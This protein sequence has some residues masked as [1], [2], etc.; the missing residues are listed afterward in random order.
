MYED[1]VGPK[2]TGII[3]VLGFL[4][5]SLVTMIN[6]HGGTDQLSTVKNILVIQTYNRGSSI[7]DT[8]DDYISESI[9]ESD[10]E[11]TNIF[12]EYLDAFRLK[13]ASYDGR[14][15]Q[16]LDLKYKDIKFDGVLCI[17]KSA[18]DFVHSYYKDYSGIPMAYIE[19]E[20]KLSELVLL[21]E[22]VGRYDV[23]PFEAII[24][25][26]K[27]LNPNLKKIGIYAN[28][29]VDLAG[30]IE[31]LDKM[32]ETYNLLYQIYS[33]DK[34][35]QYLDNM[36]DVGAQEASLLLSSLYDESGNRYDLDYLFE[37]I[38]K[39]AK[40]PV[41][42]LYKSHVGKGSTGTVLYN[43]ALYIKQSV[44]SFVKKLEGS[45]TEEELVASELLTLTEIYDYNKIKAMNLK[46]NN[47]GK[48]AIIINRPSIIDIIKNNG[49]EVVIIIF[50]VLFII[51]IILIIN[52]LLRL[53]AEKDR[54][55]ARSD[56]HL[57]YI[58][59]EAAHGQLVASEGELARQYEEL[60]LK[61]DELRKSRERYRLA[62]KGAEFGIWDYDV[63]FQRI[64]FS[65]KAREVL[66]LPMN[67]SSF[68]KEEVLSKLNKEQEATFY[69][70][71]KEHIETKTKAIEY[72]AIIEIEEG[73]KEWISVRGKA[74]F[75]E[76][77]AIKR[78]AGSIT[79]ITREKEA[80]ERIRHI[81][82]TDELTSFHNRAYFNQCIEG[83]NTYFDDEQIAILFI[84][85]DNFKTVN[86]SLGY[87]YGDKVLGK[88]AEIIKK[89]IS[90]KHE[91]MRFGGDEFIIFIREFED[92]REIEAIAELLIALF[93]KK[94]DIEGVG[95]VVT[96]SIGIALY[97]EDS[98]NI[99]VLLKHADLALNEAKSKGK[100]RFHNYTPQL[101]EAM[102]QNIW[103][104][105]ELRDA[106]NKEQFELYYQPKYD[107][108]KNSIMGFEALIRWNHPIKGIIPPNDF[109]PIAE[110]LGLII[111]I[112]EWVIKEAI[113]QLDQWHRQG[114]T[115]LSMSIN[116][117]AKQ[118]KEVHLSDV[119]NKAM[120]NKIIKANNIELEVTETTALLDIDF[121][122]EVLNDLRKQGYRVAL[123]DFG[124]GYSSLNYFNVLP[125]DVVKIDKTFIGD[126]IKEQS[127]EQIIK[128]V[129]QLAHAHNMIVV[130]EGVEKLEQLE[131]LKTEKCDIIQGYYI[132]R[133][134][135][136]EEAI[137]L[138]DNIDI[139][140]DKR[141]IT[142]Y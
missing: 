120:M 39:F 24:L 125:I 131:F 8:V 113:N 32:S 11:F 86:D 22:I 124:T 126:R 95:F 135:Q 61:G 105:R 40:S 109:I 92:R 102:A 140:L 141:N 117:S 93:Q 34:A 67:Q 84:D 17:G 62:A 52:V 38:D 18:N 3:M 81:A 10:Y 36:L 26:A 127:G 73:K 50:I 77:G 121:A 134:L 104:E 12:T 64:Y 91:I 107:L 71:I 19:V 100:N 72:K 4:L 111:P 94:L 35:Q 99:E 45:D 60:Q 1:R 110:E 128:A 136:A 68:E 23:I 28:S 47:L 119:I 114:K 5:I 137:K 108:H 106:I 20:D 75:D 89:Q 2:Y 82:F 88:I 65:N 25:N 43:Q 69:L 33:E 30:Y 55:E 142:Y 103:F 41:Y 83:G 129:V 15:A 101:E 27:K 116:L 133:P 29:Q 51:L 59:L 76:E 79:N 54:N 21:E 139:D 87:K 74:L 123:D 31:E 96:L 85:L 53:K 58:E 90:K 56:L 42:G 6:I 13:N 97:P 112:G 44:D 48:K 66:G 70:A 63:E 37:Q 98:H 118:L 7:T 138:I 16:Y 115:E 9:T 130:A 14:M 57:S 132:S 78:L 49:I 46:I 122:I 80:E